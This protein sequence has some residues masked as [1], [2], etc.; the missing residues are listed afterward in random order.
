MEQVQLETMD[1]D[2]YHKLVD[3]FIDGYR[4]AKDKLVYEQGVDIPVC[5]SLP[6]IHR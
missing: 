3:M 6:G 2:S 1:H 5:P 4:A